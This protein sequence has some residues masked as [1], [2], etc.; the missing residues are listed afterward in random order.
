MPDIRKMKKLPIS[1]SRYRKIAERNLAYV[2]KT[3][4]IEKLYNSAVDITLF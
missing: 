4:F 1:N 3:E 2:D